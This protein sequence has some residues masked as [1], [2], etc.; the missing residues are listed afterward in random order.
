MELTLLA[1]DA[2]RAYGLR[3]AAV[4][5]LRHNENAVFKIETPDGAPYILRLHKP[6]PG[7]AVTHRPDWLE[8]EMIFINALYHD[9]AIQVQK[10]IP[11]LDGQ[12][13]VNLAEAQ[14]YATLLSWLPGE[15]FNPSGEHA[16]THAY[17]AGELAAAMHAFI[18]SWPESSHL[19]RP[20]YDARRMEEVSKTLREG[21]DMGL[22]DGSACE[23]LQEGA[24]QIGLEMDKENA[25]D[26]WH[27]LIHADLGLGNMIVHNDT[28]SPIDFGLC[29]HS[30]LLFDVG[31]L[32]GAFNQAA[33]RRAALEGY[34][35]H[36]PLAPYQ[37]RAVEAF[38]LT[39]VYFFMDMH[40]GNLYV[41]EWFSRRLPHVI[42]D[43][44]EPFLQGRPFLPALLEG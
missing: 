14:G 10:P 13:V 44:V 21:V 33:L 25:H 7:L 22:F 34:E 12:W 28:V 2:L 5:L 42:S 19:P 20:A 15:T 23:T 38:F 4:T 40:R 3:P 16:V 30:P 43:Y 31:G 8:S 17:R 9:S 26:G 35:K 36:R 39:G 37:Y 1:E 18:L 6:A 24:R 27:G 41:R 11:A 32:M 29:G